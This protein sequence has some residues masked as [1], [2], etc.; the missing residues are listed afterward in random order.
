VLFGYVGAYPLR[1]GLPEGMWVR[2]LFV[3]GCLA[4]IGFTVALWFTPK[5]GGSVR[6]RRPSDRPVGLRHSNLGF[7]AFEDVME[8]ATQQFADVRFDFGVGSR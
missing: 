6:R 5:I 7:A 2:D 8:T 4:A 3:I 1:L